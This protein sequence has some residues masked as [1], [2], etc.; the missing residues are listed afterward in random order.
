MPSIGLAP[1]EVFFDKSTTGEHVVAVMP[2]PHRS[3]ADSLIC[4]VNLV[5]RRFDLNV[6]VT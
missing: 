6:N 2:K 1:R 4:H 3:R 5:G